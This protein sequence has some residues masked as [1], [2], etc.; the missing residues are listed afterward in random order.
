MAKKKSF[1]K[2]PK[3][4]ASLDTLNE[5]K[6]KCDVVSKYNAT[7]DKEAMQKKKVREDVKK[8]KAK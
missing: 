7:L 5:W 3:A 6:K 1:P 4:G 2:A 8:L